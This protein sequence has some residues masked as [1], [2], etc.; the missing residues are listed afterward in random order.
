MQEGPKIDRT[1]NR[2][3]SGSGRRWEDGLGRNKWGSEI[4]TTTKNEDAGRFEREGKT[5]KSRFGGSLLQ[6]SGR[7]G[8]GSPS[9]GYRLTAT[10]EWESRCS[11]P[12]RCLY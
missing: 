1:E 5:D 7:V 2:D 6:I 4:K 9:V 8:L 10:G 11:R 12:F 3:P